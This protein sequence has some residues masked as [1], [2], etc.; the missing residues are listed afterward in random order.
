M[1]LD[2][3]YF[4]ISLRLAQ[5]CIYSDYSYL[6]IYMLAAHLEIIWVLSWYEF[7][8]SEKIVALRIIS[9]KRIF[10]VIPA[11]GRQ[12]QVDLFEHQPSLV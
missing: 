5:T 9:S 4:I 8:R 10:P 11:L 1:W 12:S 3:S 7:Y 6:S 2:F